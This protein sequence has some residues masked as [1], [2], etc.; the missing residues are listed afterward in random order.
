MQ[1]PQGVCRGLCERGLRPRVSG[2]RRI[3][4]ALTWCST[5]VLMRSGLLFFVGN[6]TIRGLLPLLTMSAAVLIWGLA[7]RSRIVVWVGMLA[8]AASLVSNLYN[9]K[10]PVPQQFAF[11]IRFGLW[12]NI[13]LTS[14]VFVAGALVAAVT[15]R[16]SDRRQS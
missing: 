8:V 14:F 15:V 6:L 12:P 16:R 3:P 11:D 1:V 10:N 4:A 7:L 5:A 13:M 9:V 2:N